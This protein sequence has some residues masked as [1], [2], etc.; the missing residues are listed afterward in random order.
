MT[1][2]VLVDLDAVLSIARLGSFR[3]AALDLGMSTTALSNAIAK[4]AFQNDRSVLPAG[5]VLLQ[6]DVNFLQ[7]TFVPL[8]EGT[9]HQHA[10]F[11]RSHDITSSDILVG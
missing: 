8:H 7:Q 9:R 4:L 5:V 3:A 6:N 10:C 1:R 2:S 11:R